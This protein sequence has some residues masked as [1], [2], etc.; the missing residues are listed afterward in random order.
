MKKP[1]G[2]IENGDYV[3]FFNFRT[4]RGRQLTEVLTQ[5]D[6]GDMKKLKLNFITMTNYDESFCWNKKYLRKRKHF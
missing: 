5:K 1:N 3:I 4:D 6:L 2:L